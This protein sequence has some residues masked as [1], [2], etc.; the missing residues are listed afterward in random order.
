MK[1]IDLDTVDTLQLLAPGKSRN[2][3]KKACGLILSGQ[4]FAEF[5]DED[6]RT[7]WNRMKNFDGLIPSLYTF[8][9]DFKYLV[10]SGKCLMLGR[11]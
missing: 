6:R 5:S 3:A 2:D 9:E 7:I 8:F 1:K 10:K 4:A 11:Y